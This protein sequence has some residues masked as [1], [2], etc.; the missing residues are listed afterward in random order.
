MFLVKHTRLGTPVVLSALLT[1]ARGHGGFSLFHD[2]AIHSL[3]VPQPAP[4]LSWRTLSPG[5]SVFVRDSGKECLLFKKTSDLASAHFLWAGS[6]TSCMSSVFP[7]VFIFCFSCV[8]FK[9]V[10]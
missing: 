7:H 6:G 8:S 5:P 9:T 3:A 4:T 10:S 2:M 1:D